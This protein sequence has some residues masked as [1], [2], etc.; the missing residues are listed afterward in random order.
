MSPILRVFVVNQSKPLSNPRIAA[1]LHHC[2]SLN[3]LAAS[4]GLTPLLQVKLYLHGTKDL[5]EC[6][7]EATRGTV[8][9]SSPSLESGP[10]VRDL[11]HACN[12]LDKHA[13]FEDGLAMYCQVMLQPYHCPMPLTNGLAA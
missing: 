2:E 10:S 4:S 5:Q 6:Y 12:F 13:E 7:Q 3:V 11:V 9:D 8:R 1:Y